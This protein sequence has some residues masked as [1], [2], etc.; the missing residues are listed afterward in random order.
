MVEAVAAPLAKPPKLAAGV[1]AESGAG[2]KLLVAVFVPTPR[3]FGAIEEAPPLKEN[4]PAGVAAGFELENKPGAVDPFP[5]V[6][7]PAGLAPKSVAAEPTLVAGFAGVTPLEPELPKLK[8]GNVALPNK[9]G[10][11]VIDVVGCFKSNAGTASVFAADG[12]PN[13][14]PAGPVE[15]VTGV[16]VESFLSPMLPNNG[17]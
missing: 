9:E 11:F 6:S 13:E 5:F 7:V 3:D 17:G 2:L 16:V 15:P 4:P 10:V 8:A 12:A 14:N 1:P